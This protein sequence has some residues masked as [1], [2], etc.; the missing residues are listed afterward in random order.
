MADPLPPGHPQVKS[1]KIGVLLL[2]LGTPD[3]PEPFRERGLLSMRLGAHEAARADLERFLELEP[4]AS[5][6]NAI[7]AR[8]RELQAKPR[9]VN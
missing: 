8:L 1:G 6:A 3:A 9:V 5:D 2:N 7:R 4:N